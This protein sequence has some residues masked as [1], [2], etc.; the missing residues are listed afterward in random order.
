MVVRT[1]GSL[2][3][4]AGGDMKIIKLVGCITVMNKRVR[5]RFDRRLMAVESVSCAGASFYCC[6]YCTYMSPQIQCTPFFDMRDVLRRIECV[7]VT[8]LSWRRLSPKSSQK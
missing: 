5:K 3:D 6:S 4:M 2:G 1:F 8:R 7:E